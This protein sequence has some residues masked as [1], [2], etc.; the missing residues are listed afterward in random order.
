MKSNNKSPDET[1]LKSTRVSK[2]PDLEP[3]RKK[4]APVPPWLHVVP[5]ALPWLVAWLTTHATLD[6][7]FQVHS[8]A[9]PKSS[10]GEK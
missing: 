7:V 4:R 9:L 3:P 2:A 5:W 10:V 8:S 1:L 6:A